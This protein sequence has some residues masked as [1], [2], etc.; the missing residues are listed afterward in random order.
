MRTRTMRTPALLLTLLLGATVGAPAQT[1]EAESEADTTR[2]TAATRGVITGDHVIEAGQVVDE[3]VVVGG[4]LRVRGTIEEDAIVVGGDLILEPSGLV[5]GNAVVTGGRL[6]DEGGTVRGEMRTID[7]PGVDLADQIGRAVAG[8]ESAR[9]ATAAPEREMSRQRS[10]RDWFGPIWRGMAGIFST[11]MFALLIGGIGAAL[12]F[13]GR[14]YLETVSDTVRGS[15]IRSAGTGL[16]AAFLA[17][18]AFVVLIVALAVSIIGIPLLAVAVPLYPLA[19]FAGAVFGLL[20]VAHALGE[21]A[22]E[23]SG[24]RFDFRRRNSYAYLFTGLALMLAPILAA[25]ILGMTGFLGFF[26]TML[27]ILTWIAIWIAGTVGFGAVI[28]SRAG[29]RRTFVTRPPEILESDDIF[30]DD[31]FEGRDDV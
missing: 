1:P 13:F 11:L 2:Q 15:G 26:G 10:G 16:A 23:Q 19:L 20:A 8:T 6:I 12:I 31:A 18:P 3:M 25:H 27:K 28:L 14:P 7:A 4:D 30:V 5:G 17:I 29:T 9:T 21:R 22:A 24:D